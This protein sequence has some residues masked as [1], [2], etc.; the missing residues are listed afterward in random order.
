MWSLFVL[1]GRLLPQCLQHRAPLRTAPPSVAGLRGRAPQHALVEARTWAW[2]RRSIIW[3]ALGWMYRRKR[4]SAPYMN[5]SHRST[6][7]DLRFAQGLL[8]VIHNGIL[9]CAA[10][11]TAYFNQAAAN[12]IASAIA[13]RIPRRP[14]TGQQGPNAHANPDLYIPIIQPISAAPLWT[15]P[16]S[17]HGHPRA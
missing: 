4:P 15:R 8:Q 11:P 9:A 1:A 12:A 2:R 7:C 6:A 10:A 13:L 3:S 17:A 14:A 5:G 16:S